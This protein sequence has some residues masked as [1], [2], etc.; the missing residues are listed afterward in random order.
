VYDHRF[1]PRLQ[2]DITTRASQEFLRRGVL[3]RWQ[4]GE[5]SRD[6]AGR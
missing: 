3:Q 1:E 4:E 6:I 2:S 5:A